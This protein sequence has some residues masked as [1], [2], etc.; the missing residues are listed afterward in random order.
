[1]ERSVNG[2][3]AGVVDLCIGIYR[4]TQMNVKHGTLW[5]LTL[6]WNH[7]SFWHSLNDPIPY[8]KMWQ[9]DIFWYPLLLENKCFL[10]TFDFVN[11]TTMV[12]HKVEE[13]DQLPFVE[14]A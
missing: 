5:K 9:D 10:G 8:D 2:Y 4:I 6:D 7:W 1:M 11:T 3:V 12:S 13:V 14:G